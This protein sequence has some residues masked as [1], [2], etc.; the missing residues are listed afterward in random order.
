MGSLAYFIRSGEGG[1]HYTI[2]SYMQFHFRKPPCNITIPEAYPCQSVVFQHN[3]V[4]NH[5]H[6]LVCNETKKFGERGLRSFRYPNFQGSHNQF[7][8][9]D[10]LNTPVTKVASRTGS[11]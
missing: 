11:N 2:L 1:A 5:I 10:G 8:L 9:H 6:T 4:R 7:P 3:K